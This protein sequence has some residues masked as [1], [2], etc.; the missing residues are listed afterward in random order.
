M[1]E[2]GKYKTED[3]GIIRK[4]GSANDPDN[5]LHLTTADSVLFGR[6][7]SYFRGYFDIKDAVSDPEYATTV[8]FTKLM[9]SEYQNCDFHNKGVEEFIRNSMTPD[10]S[11]E[12][13]MEEIDRIKLEIKEN[14]LNDISAGWVR[15]W[16]GRKQKNGNRDL[17]T[18]EIREFIEGSL[19]PAESVVGSIKETSVKK[20]GSERIRII[21]YISLAAAAIIGVVF[22]IS[23]I[24]PSSNPDK[25]FSKYYEPYSAVSSVTRSPGTRENDFF[26]SALESYMTGNYQA[27]AAGFSGVL[28]NQEASDAP[29]FFLGITQ[30]ALNDFSTAVS[31]LEEVSAGQGEFT[32]ESIWY[33]GL[34]SLKTG[35]KARASECFEILAQTPGFYR[36]RSVKILRRLK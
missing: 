22:I 25:I 7:T 19:E 36:E 9:I 11:D 15:E 1:K 18:E 14:N 5:D 24:L 35:N 12:K 13:T 27:A 34:A 10:I 28:V 4:H 30:I 3:P 20:S 23:S 2:Q 33:L 29:H 26:S 16:T 32:K 31:L 21:S 8:D 17:K 6:I